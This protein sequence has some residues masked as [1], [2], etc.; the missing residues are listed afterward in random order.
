MLKWEEKMTASEWR[1][2]MNH[3]VAEATENATNKDEMRGKVVVIVPDDQ[4]QAGEVAT[5]WVRASEEEAWV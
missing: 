2:L 5:L 3:L 4:A 1:V